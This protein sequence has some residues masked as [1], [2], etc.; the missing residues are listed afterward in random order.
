[1][2]AGYTQLTTGVRVWRGLDHFFG[3][4]SAWG[5]QRIKHLLVL[6]LLVCGATATAGRH[7]I[8]LRPILTRLDD[9]FSQGTQLLANG[10][11][12]FSLVSLHRANQASGVDLDNPELPLMWAGAFGVM[13]AINVLHL[14]RG[15]AE[16]VGL[17][18]FRDLLLGQVGFERVDEFAHTMIPAGAAGQ[19]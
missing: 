12:I 11:V 13:A 4:V 9:R 5:S 17:E 18:D 16:F 3:A 14:V 1:M 2:D 6:L 10:L 15:G 7:H 8:S 19:S